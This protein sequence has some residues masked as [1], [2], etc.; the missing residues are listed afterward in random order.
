MLFSSLCFSVGVLI[1][2]NEEGNNKKNDTRTRRG[3]TNIF[4]CNLREKKKTLEGQM[5][6]DL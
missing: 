3:K 2:L 5:L 1:S 6:L 4:F